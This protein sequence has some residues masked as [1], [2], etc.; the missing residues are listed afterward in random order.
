MVEGPAVLRAPHDAGHPFFE[1]ENWPFN[2]PSSTSFRPVYAA[3]GEGVK[4]SKSGRP[5]FI[6][7]DSSD[8]QK[9]LVEVLVPGGNLLRH[10]GSGIPLVNGKPGLPRRSAFQQ[11]TDGGPVAKADRSPG[12]VRFGQENEGQENECLPSS[13]YP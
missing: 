13:S 2:G 5:G 1:R 4:A 8:G 11:E 3:Q 10:V 7:R 12:G 9:A 6:G